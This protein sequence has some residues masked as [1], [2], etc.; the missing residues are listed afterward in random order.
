[1]EV[2]VAKSLDV[3]TP[4]VNQANSALY[5]IYIPD[6]TNMT[7]FQAKAEIDFGISFTIP[8]GYFGSIVLSPDVARYGISLL[9]GSC[10]FASGQPLKCWVVN[11]A[12]AQYTFKGGESY[13]SVLFLPKTQVTLS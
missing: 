7:L 2:S 13:F 11:T 1:M 3:K 5:D 10:F 6:D 8:D 9:G 4:V 12:T